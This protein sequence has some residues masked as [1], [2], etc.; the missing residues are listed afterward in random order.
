MFCDKENINLLTALLPQYGVRHVVVCPGSRNAAL[1]HNFDE[2]PDLECYPVTDERSAGFVALGLSLAQHAPVAVCV[3]SGSALLGVLPAAAE[4]TYQHQGIIVISADRPQAWI[5]QLDGQTM[6]QQGTLD[7]FVGKSVS[8]PEPHTEDERWMCRRQICEALMENQKSHHPSVH[9][10]VPLSEPL[11]SFTTEAL[12]DV[13]AITLTT[14]IDCVVQEFQQAQRPML[15]SGQLSSSTAGVEA[16]TRQPIVFL[17]EKL[18]CGDPHSLPELALQV[19]QSDPYKEQE[20]Y[21]PDFI[22][23]IGGNTVSK[24]LRHTLRRYAQHAKVVMVSETGELQDITQHADVVLQVNS[25][26][27]FL[28]RMADAEFTESAFSARWNR[29]LEDCAARAHR[30]HP[31]YSQAMAIQLFEEQIAEAPNAA[32]FYGNSSSVR[33][34]E[35][36]ARHYNFCNRG[37]NGIEGSLSTAV[38][39]SLAYEGQTYCIIGDLSFFYDQNALWNNALRGNLRIL[40]INNGGGSIF[41]MLPGLEDSP[42]RDNLASAQHSTTAEGLCQQYFI[43]YRTAHQEAT[44]REGISWLI[45][46][47]SDR[48]LLLEVFTCSAID[49]V[50]YQQILDQFKENDL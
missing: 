31:V 27:N 8:I 11:F 6:P 32:V 34:G 15:V 18:C 5:G 43:E 44:L 41:R 21:A 40:L 25:V 13:K 26:E 39:Y 38:G 29:L 3:T 50:I 35:I 22:V 7:T 37:L 16:L 23:Y 17:H 9:I 4:A 47:E 42:A 2:S 30:L 10:N 49:A 20:E 14:D 1:A 19:L 33:L 12:P 45:Q 48:P 36:F 28:Q 46:T 24:L